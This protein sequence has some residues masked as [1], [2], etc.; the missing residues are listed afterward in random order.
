[1]SKPPKI[2]GTL[3]TEVVNT[4]LCMYCGACIASCPVNVV[5]YSDDEKPTLA[6]RCVLCELC[7]YGCPRVELPL[8]SIEKL[9]FGR[10]RTT[11][12]PL[13]VKTG[14]FSARC[15]NENV[16]SKSQDGGVVTALLQYALETE[17]AD[18]A[19]LIGKDYH[20]PWKPAPAIASIADEVL[21]H[22]GS[23]YTATGSLGALAEAA[24]GYPNSN[25][26][27]VGVPCQIQGLRRIATSPHAASK[28]AERV[29]LAV[30]LFCYNTYKYN[31]LFVDYISQQQKLDLDRITRID[32]KGGRFKALYGSEVKLDVSVKGL[33]SFTH[34][35][36][37]KCRDFT[38]ELADISIG[39]AGSEEGWCTV[40]TRTQEA[41][42]I[43][44]SAAKAGKLQLKQADDKLDSIVRL[45]ESKR[46]REAPYIR[47]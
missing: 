9:I 25:L 31:P 32:I 5:A 47:S 38:A 43:L 11:D 8:A 2:F 39:H 35:G 20:S 15:T 46:R 30:G 12:E 41:H 16:L 7:Y 23:K 19:I 37:A 21:T 18:H 14:L 10:T 1:M 34:P 26:A 29:K 44:Q 28:L 45:S 40:I 42:R 6:G 17:L 22:S 33:E 3:L 36:C 27:F 4:G 24:I 13:G